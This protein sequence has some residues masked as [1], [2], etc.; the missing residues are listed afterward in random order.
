MTCRVRS[1]KV[2]SNV[3]PV[4]NGLLDD[5]DDEDEEEDGEM[6]SLQPEAMMGMGDE[7]DIQEQ[8]RT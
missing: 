6:S 5:V 2:G 7:T 8:V 1:G 3:G 4:G